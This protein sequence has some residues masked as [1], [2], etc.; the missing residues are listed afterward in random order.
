MSSLPKSLNDTAWEQLFS[1]YDILNQVDANGR[2]EISATQIKEFRE[3]RLMAKFDHTINLPKIFANNQLAILPITRGDYI[4]S[5][6]DAYHKFEV[7]NSPVTRVSLPTYIQSLDSN[8]VPSEAIAL[9]CAIAANIVSDFLQDEDLVSTVSRRMS[10]GSFSFDIANSKTA[11][12]CRVQVDNAQ[13]EID[14]AY[15]GVRGLALF[16]AKRDIS[17]DFL[18][19]QLYYPF[20]VWQSRIT[21]PVRPLFLV[22]SNGI[23]RLYEYAFQDANNYS[24]LVF[25]KRKNYS[26]EDTA[27]EITDI[28]SVLRRVIIA[29]EPQIPFPQADSFE[30]VINICELLNEQELSRNDVTEQYAFDARQTNYYTDAARFLVCLKN[31]VT[32]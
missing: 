29:P 16:E 24:S 11:A 13:I 19:R 26:I 22:Y 6:F 14:A 31:T 2:F 12:P 4:I 20:R 5:H 28:Q 3:P 7:D 15:E 8:N 1:K 18:V 23:Y 17:E 9:N 30:R 21:K 10:S 25:V 32:V 27:I